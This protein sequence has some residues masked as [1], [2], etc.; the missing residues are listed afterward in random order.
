MKG[1]NT[2]TMSKM[3]NSSI[4]TVALFFI[5]LL[6]LSG[7]SVVVSQDDVD[8]SGQTIT[9][10]HQHGSGAA[11]EAIT[12]LVEEFNTTN[13]WG[14]TVEAQYQGQYDQLREIMN[15]SI[16]SGDLPNVIAG[17][18][19]DA[20]S[21][22]LDGAIVDLDDYYNDPVWGFTDEE[23]DDFNQSI[24]ALGMHNEKRLAWPLQVSPQIM[25][26]NLTMMEELGLDGPPTTF[27]EFE[28]VLCEVTSIAAPGE[29]NVRGMPIAPH[30]VSEFEVIVQSRG[31]T[32]FEDGAYTFTNQ[33]VLETLQMYQDLYNAGCAY[34]P[35]TQFGNT[36]DFAAGLNPLTTTVTAGLPFIISGMETAGVD[37]DWTITT[38]PWTEGNRTIQIFTPSV[39]ITRGA[40]EQQLASW[41][42][43]QFLSS[44]A[45]QAYSTATTGYF[46]PR[47][48]SQDLLGDFEAEN[49]LLAIA[50]SLIN[51]DSIRVYDQPQLVSYQ[52][53]RG[54]ISEAIADV[55]INGMSVEDVA[56][57]LEAA[58]NQ[59]HADLAE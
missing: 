58:A 50:N 9:Y 19:R 28:E 41:L 23:K 44:P 47:L 56:A 24:L 10:W 12:T 29:G 31:G 54:L 43:V 16:I 51:D 11:E 38:V 57:R 26:V 21:Y 32:I 2:V 40:P 13:E 20:I 22:D 37:V 59:T 49:P 14:I 27:A 45:A 25:V 6:A 53:V 36:D 8:P 46:N 18:R 33:A 42:F 1:L 30:S 4:K 39:M 5:L 17:Y 3:H 48:S 52:L 55:T 15:V 35:E 7:A 34:F